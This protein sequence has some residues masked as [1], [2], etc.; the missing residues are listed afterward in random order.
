MGS[1]ACGL[2]KQFFAGVVGTPPI[3]GKCEFEHLTT[4]SS[5]ISPGCCWPLPCRYRSVFGDRVRGARPRYLHELTANGKCSRKEVPL[6]I[7]G[8]LQLATCSEW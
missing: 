7:Q 4:A 3:A 8:Q 2:G 5:G 6:Y 1:P